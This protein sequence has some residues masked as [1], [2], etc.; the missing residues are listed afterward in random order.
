MLFKEINLMYL[1]FLFSHISICFMV[2]YLLWDKCHL[3]KNF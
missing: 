3:K 2:D 1:I